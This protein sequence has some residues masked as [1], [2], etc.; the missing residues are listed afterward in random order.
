MQIKLFLKRLAKLI[1][2]MKTS[3]KKN[4]VLYILETLG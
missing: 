3:Q 4:A 2:L 1:V